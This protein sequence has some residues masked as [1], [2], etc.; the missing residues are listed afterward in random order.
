MITS[1]LYNSTIH[2]RKLDSTDVE[3][4][5]SIRLLCWRPQYLLAWVKWI[6][7]F[8][9]TCRSQ[10]SSWRRIYKYL[11]LS[12]K[13]CF[14]HCGIRFKF[15]SLLIQEDFGLFWVSKKFWN[16][17][18]IGKKPPDISKTEPLT[19]LI[20]RY[21]DVITLE[22]D[23][24]TQEHRTGRESWFS[25]QTSMC[26]AHFTPSILSFL[27]FFHTRTSSLVFYCCSISACF[28]TIAQLKFIL[29]PTLFDYFHC[30]PALILGQPYDDS[31]RPAERGTR[32]HS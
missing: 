30:L 14:L 23:I 2:I 29:K 11:P 13:Q 19:C 20:K 4:R 5:P 24:E 27:F 1:R 32:V 16:N 7:T 26:W 18:L 10:W 12:F 8:R 28:I 21:C 3:W 31:A 22:M 17:L 15:C 25:F 6:N 9:S